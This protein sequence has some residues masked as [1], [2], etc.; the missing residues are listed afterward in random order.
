MPDPNLRIKPNKFIPRVVVD[1]KTKFIRS[2]FGPDLIEGQV[3]LPPSRGVL[4]TSE[5]VQRGRTFVDNNFHQFIPQRESL[6]EISSLQGQFS[7]SLDYS[8]TFKGIPVYGAHLVVGLRK[9]D[10]F[11]VSTVNTT[12][13][14]IPE[15]LETKPSLN[16]QQAKAVI[17]NVK[18]G[19]PETEPNLFIYRHTESKPVEPE[20][21]KNIRSQMLQSAQGQ[22]D[23]LYLAYSVYSRNKGA[24]EVLLDA[25]NGKVIDVKDR[26]FYATKGKVFWPDPIRTKK[27]MKVKWPPD[28]TSKKAIEKLNKQMRDVTLQNLDQA[29]EDGFYHLNGKYVKNEDIELPTYTPP[30]TKGDFIYD[31]TDREFR[32]VMAY[33]YIDTLVTYLL[34]LGNKAYNENV[35]PTSPP[36]VTSATNPIT[37]DAQGSEGMD[38]YF[39]LDS[40]GIPYISFGEDISGVRCWGIPDATDPGLITHEYGHVLHHFLLANHVNQDSAYE[41]GFCD[42][43]SCCWLD[44][45]NEKQYKR[46]EVMVWDRS[47]KDMPNRRGNLACSQYNFSTGFADYDD[48]L[49]GDIHASALWDIYKKIGG[50]KS[51]PNDRI[52]AADDIISLYMDML[53][54]VRVNNPLHVLVEGLIEACKNRNGSGAIT[55]AIIRNAYDKRGLWSKI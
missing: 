12:D 27:T 49:K 28:E 22:K 50:S 31:A 26:R 35:V 21:V 17:T 47:V 52:K 43:L 18:L 11:V 32:N 51:N 55:E 14:E 48:Y 53:V 3:P 30:K 33:Y 36:S 46:A 54:L 37:I 39:Q 40:E 41:E 29:D 7:N 13:S 38:S 25:Q 1:K 15:T 24:W 6:V 4:T 19:V 20:N 8:Q 45:F 16:P 42:F 23:Q 9:S 5:I 10:A 44:R 2:F 34:S